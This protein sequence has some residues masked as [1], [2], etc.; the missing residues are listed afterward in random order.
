MALLRPVRLAP[1]L[2]TAANL[3]DI[4]KS[5]AIRRATAAR[6][7]RCSKVTVDRYLLPIGSKHHK[8][9][10]LVRWELFRTKVQAIYHADEPLEINL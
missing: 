3:H 10:P 8:K 4:M 6:L 2:P 1:L 5:H 9:I 7:M